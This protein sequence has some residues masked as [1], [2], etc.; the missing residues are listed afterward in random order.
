MIAVELHRVLKQAGGVGA[1]IDRKAKATV[2]AVCGR[3][4]DVVVLGAVEVAAP[5]FARDHAFVR[6][7]L[8]LTLRTIRGETTGTREICSSPTSPASISFPMTRAKVVQRT[9]FLS[10]CVDDD[11]GMTTRLVCN[12]RSNCAALWIS[13]GDAGG[14]QS[15]G[16]AMSNAVAVVHRTIS[17]LEVF[18]SLRAERSNP[19]RVTRCDGD[20]RVAAL[21]EMTGR[22]LHGRLPGRLASR[23]SAFHL[24]A[25]IGEARMTKV[26][27]LDDWQGVART[28]ADWSPL[29]ARAEVVF[30]A[31]AFDNEDDAARQLADFDIVLSMRERTPL[32]GSLI[33]RL[34]KL[35]MLGMTGARNASLDTPACTARG[36]VVCNTAGGG[37]SE[38]ATAELALGLLIAAARAIP[39]GTPTS[40]RE[41]SRRACRSATRCK[42]RQWG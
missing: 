30:F 36:V 37:N 29:Q 20:C 7:V 33:N 18:L 23:R 24:A 15:D 14:G 5:G 11:G 9:V 4:E 34:P 28:S 27:V 1:T 8:R 10:P 21:L 22:R 31:K 32:P 17:I 39:P 41:S 6:R 26:A 35:R 38:A 42:A 3:E 16:N 25:G 13:R 19:Y 12:G 40:A 2:H